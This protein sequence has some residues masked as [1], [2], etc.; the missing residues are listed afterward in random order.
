MNAFRHLKL[1]SE[2]FFSRNIKLFGELRQGN[3]PLTTLPKPKV[4][5]TVDLVPVLA[6]LDYCVENDL[7]F[8]DTVLNI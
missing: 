4:W 5:N 6:W 3:D 2:I 1:V 8:R 7:S